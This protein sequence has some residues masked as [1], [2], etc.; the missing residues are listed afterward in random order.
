[1]C[2]DFRRQAP[3][4]TYCL[5][6]AVR[7]DHTGLYIPARSLRSGPSTLR[8]HALVP[9]ARMH[10][11]RPDAFVHV[12]ITRF[13]T[14]GRVGRDQEDHP[15]V[16]ARKLPTEA[17]ALG[18]QA[19]GRSACGD[20]SGEDGLGSRGS[21]SGPRR[22]GPSTAA[23][24]PPAAGLADAIPAGDGLRQLV[25]AWSHLTRADFL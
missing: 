12:T 22:H 16:P 20:L 2:D 17:C 5:A 15:R 7:H 8:P 9:C 1:M 11:R 3:Q 13:Y 25:D 24:R 18:L 19:S 6:R 4:A 23:A 10:A 21:S 14:R